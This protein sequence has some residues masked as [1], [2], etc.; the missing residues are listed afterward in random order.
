MEAAM[1]KRW[2]IGLL[3]ILS[4]SCMVLAGPFFPKNI[5]SCALA[6]PA[7]VLD[8]NTATAD[9]LK[10]LPGIGDAYADK[11]IKGRPYKRKDEL[12]QK[13]IVPQ[14]T[15]DKIKEQVVAKQK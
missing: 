8:L 12:V 9:Q 6:A 14:A 7:E 11:I 13:K 4:V 2:S 10:G 3:W 15:S 5:D 1:R